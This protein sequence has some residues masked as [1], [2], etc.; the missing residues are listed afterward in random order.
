ML[1]TYYKDILKDIDEQP[2]E[3]M[4]RA[5]YVGSICAHSRISPPGSLPV[6]SCLEST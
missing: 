2:N 5:G 3:E 4:H 6:F 1:P